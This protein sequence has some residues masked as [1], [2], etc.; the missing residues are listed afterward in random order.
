MT[1]APGNG[2]PS[3][4]RTFPLIVIESLI[5]NLGKT[6]FQDGWAVMIIWLRQGLIVYFFSGSAASVFGTMSPKIPGNTIFNTI[7]TRTFF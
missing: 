2:N 7:P 5:G 4:S 3:E 6:L 1:S